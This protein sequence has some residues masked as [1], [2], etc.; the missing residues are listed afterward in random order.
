MLSLSLALVSPAW[1]E[2]AP[3]RVIEPD[4]QHYLEL[5]RQAQ[6]SDQQI[7]ALLTEFE[8]TLAEA[9]GTLGKQIG[10][11]LD[12]DEPTASE[13]DL[14]VASTGQAGEKIIAAT[15]T[16]L[17]PFRFSDRELSE[18]V[19][20]YWYASRFD[21]LMVSILTPPRPVEMIDE[22]RMAPSVPFGYFMAGLSRRVGVYVDAHSDKLTLGKELRIA[23]PLFYF[24]SNGQ[25]RDVPM[26]EDVLRFLRNP[27]MRDVTE[28]LHDRKITQLRE[29][30]LQSSRG[31]DLDGVAA[32]FSTYGENDILEPQGRILIYDANIAYRG[33]KWTADWT[34]AYRNAIE[35]H[36]M[37]HSL[38]RS[39]RSGCA[40]MTTTQAQELD[41]AQAQLST[42]AVLAVERD[43]LAQVVASLNLSL[44]GSGQKELVHEGFYKPL[45]R[46]IVQ[47][48]SRD[49]APVDID[50]L[51]D[52]A[53]VPI[54]MDATAE[55]MVETAHAGL[56]NLTEHVASI[57]H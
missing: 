22:V 4:Y 33:R 20:R 34:R 37:M 3:P 13:R 47:R 57:C 19:P 35:I 16:L 10:P 52:P 51:D 53:K 41:E 17:A 5:G 29:T 31:Y 28:K 38:H 30:V 18:L 50:H 48:S 40:T 46:K 23:F 12:K 54:L 55:E 6:L 44:V 8:N 21:K 24:S 27:A 43:P 14:V 1:A 45:M 15:R 11:V 32:H 49:G 56:V 39:R 9:Y 2:Y 25:D 42:L 26:R 7:Q 36:E